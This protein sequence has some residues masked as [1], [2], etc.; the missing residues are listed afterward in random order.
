MTDL[1]QKIAHILC[2]VDGSASACRAADHAAWLAAKLGARL[3]FVAVAREGRSN[4]ALDAYK[5]SEGLGD[6]PLPLMSAEAE[7]CL[8]VA[9]AS[10]AFHGVGS[11]QKLIR[12][13]KV[14]PT[15][16]AAAT[17]VGAD[18]IV[19]GRHRHSEIRRSLLGSVSRSIA[20]ESSLNLLQIC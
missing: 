1:E 14:A 19:L 15:L 16:L 3:T 9:Q 10:A 12:V 18:T 11:V 7:Q 4:A 5:K 17:E 6:E 13:G 8:Q 20:A 2:G